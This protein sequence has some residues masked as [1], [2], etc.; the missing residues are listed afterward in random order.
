MDATL[1]AIAVSVNVKKEARD[2]FGPLKATL[3][4]I[5][6]VRTDSKHHLRVPTEDSS[7]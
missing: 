6:T 7:R 4:A 2:G 1:G 5:F 3:E